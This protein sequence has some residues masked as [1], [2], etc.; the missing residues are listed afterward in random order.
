MPSIDTVKRINV[1]EFK[2]EDREVAERIANIYN[3]FA[4]QVTN[5]INGKLDFSNLNRAIVTVEVTAGTNGNPIQTTQFNSS[6]G[7]QGV[8]VI[9]A[10]NLTNRAN[11][12][13]STP[14][15]SFTASGTGVYTID[16]ITG[17]NASQRYRLTLELIF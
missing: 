1:D 8:N 6:T 11:F 15:I 2:Q 17:L 5:V 4:E 14:F 7:L 10:V 9:Q 3:Y 16:N 13:Q 12:L